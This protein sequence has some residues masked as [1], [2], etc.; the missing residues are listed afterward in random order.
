[1][2]IRLGQVIAALTALAILFMYRGTLDSID[3]FFQDK[4]MQHESGTDNRIVVVGIDDESIQNI[5]KWPWNRKIHAQLID[6]LTQ[7][8]PAVIAFDVTF[9]VPSDDPEENIELIN[10]VKRAG[11]VVMAR[12][13]TFDSSVKQGTIEALELSEPFPELKEAAAGVGHIN[14]IPDE[15]QV[16]RKSLYMFNYK[17]QPMES[18]SWIIYKIFKKHEGQQVNSKE[19]PLD[20][21]NRYHIPYA[22]GPG[23]FEV[24]PYSSIINGD[25]PPDYFQDRIVLIGPYT[26]GLK[27]DY[28]TPLDYKTKMYGVEI[29][30]NI[31]QAL[32]EQNFKRELDWKWNAA[33]LV[34]TAIAVYYLFRKTHPGISFTVLVAIIIVLIFGG[35]YLYGKG[36][37][38]SIGYLISFLVTSYIV[39]IGFNYMKEL[40][41]RRRVTDIFGRYVAPQVVSQILESGEQGLKLGGTRRELTVLFVDIRGFTPLSE[42]AEPEEIVE[43]LNEYLDLTATCIFRYDGTLDKFI[44]DATMAIFNAPLLLEDHQ[45]KAVQAA[46]AM[47]EGAIALEKKLME[48]FGRSVKFG[49]GIHTGPAVFGNI[50]SKTR[51]DYTAIGDTVNTTARLESNA[52]PG[53]IILSETIYEAVKE[54]ITVVPLGEIKVKGKEQGIRIYELEGLK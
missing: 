10:A 24:V 5:G 29:H 40:L 32:L 42:Q 49:I 47:K 37:I 39:V 46:W 23:Q 20:R 28:P 53:Q 50:G 15:D 18:F 45:L 2:R 26:V 14:T 54:H 48:R 34:F 25:V 27:D 17:G 35:K 43:I 52:K 38:I 12:Y 31:I 33:V 21:F 4:F 44:G 1:M 9:P 22:G 11:N 51:M 19:L 13:G 7:G 6:T 41:E 30:A 16:V 8:H 3:F 36:I